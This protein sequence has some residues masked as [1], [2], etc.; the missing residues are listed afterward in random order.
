MCR[1][2]VHAGPVRR[3][4]EEW[5]QDPEPHKAQRG[6]VQALRV[7]LSPVGPLGFQVSSFNHILFSFLF[8]GYLSI[9]L[10]NS[11]S[12]GLFADDCHQNFL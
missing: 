2:Y 1:H 10:V 12:L 11:S 3:A 8:S 7:S 9:P 5:S 4:E 6:R